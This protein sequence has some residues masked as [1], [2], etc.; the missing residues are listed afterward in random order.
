MLL[1][2][3]LVLPN[4]VCAK[5]AVVKVRGCDGRGRKGAGLGGVL[6]GAGEAEAEGAALPKGEAGFW[7]DS[8]RA[9]IPLLTASIGRKHCASGLKV[10]FTSRS[11]ELS[12]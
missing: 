6:G 5:V 11:A 3:S 10:L 12:S 4:L 7:G 9:A 1:V 2:L 8:E